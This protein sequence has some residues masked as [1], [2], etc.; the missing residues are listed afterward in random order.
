MGFASRSVSI[1]RYRV[2]GET[3]GSFW[4]AVDQGVRKGAFRE[5]TGSDVVGLGWVSSQDFTDNAFAGASYVHGNYVALSLRIDTVRVPPRLLE[6]QV[7]ERTREILERTGQK[8]LSS[9]QRRELRDSVRETLM[10]QAL[11]SIQVHDLVWDTA[12]SVAYLS[13]LSQKVRDEVERVFKHS[14]GMKLVPLIPY[15]RAMELLETPTD[16]QS[17]ESLTPVSFL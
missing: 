4:D 6:L 15:A 10:S 17:L 5:G 2:V 3:E 7:M 13:S 16:R 8:R 14:F 11:R 1:T 12:Q 9:A